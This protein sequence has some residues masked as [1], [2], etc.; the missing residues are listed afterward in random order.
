[1]AEKLQNV[2]PNRVWLSLTGIC[3]NDCL[4]C[5]RKGSEIATFLNRDFIVRVAKT[6]SECG[7]KSCVI[8]GGEPTLHPEFSS[9]ADDLCSFFQFCNLITNGRSFSN[10]IP[11]SV[12]KNIPHLSISVSMHGT[13]RE[14]YFANTGASEGFD[15]MC[16]GLKNLRDRNI[17]FS[18][19]VVLCP[20]NLGNVGD[21][22]ALAKKFEAKSLC[23][24][25]GLPSLDD[26]RQYKTDPV[27]IADAI[28][29]IFR[30]CKK[31]EQ[32]CCFVISL[33]WCLIEEMTL[34]EIMAEKSLMFNCP[35][36]T[37]NAV[38]IKENRAI[39]LC[40]HTT[41]FELVC[42]S[43]I[44]SVISS[45]QSFI[46]F[47]SGSEMSRLRRT[48]DVFRH[49][50]CTNCDYRWWCRGGCPLWWNSFDFS[51]MISNKEGDP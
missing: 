39:S 3:D 17:G 33:P 12:I 16:Q 43:E 13:N 38:T 6:L 35:V 28:P 50:K 24:T 45:S 26:T 25:F 4:W 14:H 21:C 49:R 40:T 11:L 23:F 22:I 37:G 34:R 15:E 29:D 31:L 10:G 48:I 41:G 8:T 18:V 44:D 42:P 1:M 9:I 51:G 47:W 2:V 19:N 30:L 20:E 46:D 36:F 32:K 7:T 5:L 27:L